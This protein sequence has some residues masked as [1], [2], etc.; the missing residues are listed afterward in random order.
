MTRRVFAN[1]TQLPDFTSSGSN[2]NRFTLETLSA[3]LALLNSSH[4]KAAGEQAFWP[5]DDAGKVLLRFPS[6]GSGA[7]VDFSRH[8]KALLVELD[9]GTILVLLLPEAGAHG[10]VSSA[11]VTFIRCGT[12]IDGVSAVPRKGVL[13][14]VEGNR[15]TSIRANSR[16][17]P[18]GSAST[19]VD[20]PNAT[21]LP[22]LID[23][24]VHL[25]VQDPER[26]ELKTPSESLSAANLLRTLRYGFTTV[27][28]LGTVGLGPSDLDVRNAVAGGAL[29]GPRLK[30]AICDVA[31]QNFGVEGPTEL[32]AAVDRIVDEGSDWVKLFDIAGP[33]PFGIPD[34]DRR[35]QYSD[36]EISAIVDE[37]HKRGVKVAMH[38][39]PFAGSHNAIAG[40]VDSLEH[41]VDIEDADIRRMKDYGMTFVPT[42]FVIPYVA[43]LPSRNDHALWEDRTRRSF[44]TFER[45]LKA[46]VQIAFGTD[47]G[48]QN[49][50][51]TPAQQFQMMVSHGM[52]PMDAIQSATITAARLLGMDKQIGSIEAGKLADIVAVRGDPLAD[53]SRLEHVI[54]VM[55][56]G[57]PIG[58]GSLTTLGSSESNGGR[59]HA[60]RAAT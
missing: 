48:A 47:A 55:K 31:T 21:C 4:A 5:P 52:A 27:R 23:V 7:T 33:P 12:L 11:P 51:S 35:S 20:P 18:R 40:H 50:T 28:N 39:I 15:I 46:K 36:E 22:G 45:A 30:V 38:T 9:D 56:D 44:D 8:E 43:A 34:S 6:H 26:R 25:I 2:R 1:R 10:A 60:V 24:H 13:L 19:T 14:R 42:L 53:V 58:L 57:R 59:G 16:T 54:F 3:R 37:A 29:P 41:G 32:S 49:W 17:P